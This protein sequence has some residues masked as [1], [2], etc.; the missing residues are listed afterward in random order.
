MVRHLT[1][2]ILGG[3][4]ST[5]FLVGNAEACHK[6]NCRQHLPAPAGLR[7]A[8]NLLPARPVPAEGEVLQDQD[9][10][11]EVLPQEVVRPGCSGLRDAGR[12]HLS[13]GLAT[14]LVSA[15][16]ANVFPTPHE[17]LLHDELPVTVV[18]D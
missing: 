11:A 18:P 12:V 3:I 7:D 8:G 2:L 5:V 9:L 16:T 10:S 4:F 17:Q 15:L 1:T 13:R 6:R 14:G